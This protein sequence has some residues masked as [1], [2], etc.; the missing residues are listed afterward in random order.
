MN[1]RIQ[2]IF[3]FLEIFFFSN[4]M[5]RMKPSVS[6]GRVS[7]S[8]CYT[9]NNYTNE[10]IDKLKLL[11]VSKH[12]SCEEI[13]EN[14]TPHLQGAITFKRAYRM[15]QLK[16]L[17]ETAHWEI[18]KTVDAENYCIK[19]K[20]IIDINNAKQGKRT[21]LE[22][23]CE[24]ARTKG[25]REVASELPTTYVRYHKGLEKLVDI[26]A[27]DTGYVKPEVIVIWGKPGTGKSKLAR[28][29]DPKLYNVMNPG[30]GTLWFDG[31]QGQET[32]LFDDFYDWVNYSLWL[33][34]LDGYKM[35]MQIKGGTVLRNWTRVIV[36]SNKNPEEWY[37][38]EDTSAMR[39]R[40]TE[41][42]HL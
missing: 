14:G 17:F 1:L 35:R 30:N 2:Q 33:Q 24:L 27:D 41:T 3:F 16:K 40:I 42:I 8:W 36:T 5:K 12:R 22:T 10:I 34:I 20:V 38:H 29:I 21:D 9:I 23:A 4:D 19:G 26:L 31:Y 28:E 39:R 15:T 6:L 25:M 37:I 7:K 11:E 32:I 13:G 18:T